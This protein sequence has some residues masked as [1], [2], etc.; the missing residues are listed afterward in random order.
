MKLW[1]TSYLLLIVWLQQIALRIWCHQVLRGG[2]EVYSEEL[3]CLSLFY[4]VKEGY[5][6]VRLL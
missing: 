1:A 2:R 5:L 6:G 4:F 3:I